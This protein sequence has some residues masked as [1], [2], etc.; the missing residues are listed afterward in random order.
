MRTIAKNILSLIALIL[1]GPQSFAKGPSLTPDLTLQQIVQTLE[2][3]A[4]ALIPADMRATGF[5]DF[6]VDQNKLS[7][8]LEKVPF[9]I[10]VIGHE[11]VAFIVN[12]QKFSQDDVRTRR[13]LKQAFLRKF[14][15]APQ[16]SLLIRLFVNSAFAAE[17][18]NAS[19][20]DS[21]FTG[22]VKE[23]KAVDSKVSVEQFP[24]VVY[25]QKSFKHPVYK[26]SDFKAMRPFM[27]FVTG[28]SMN[29]VFTSMQFL[30]SGLNHYMSNMGAAKPFLD[31]D[32][33]PTAVTKPT[34]SVF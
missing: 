30:F 26:P 34:F 29:N 9:L 10:E 3:S 6:K 16:Y 7:F 12:G 4:V 25:N 15:R 13:S 32:P 21:A 31:G 5:Y 19:F 27:N 24:P 20:D 2:P 17:P 33:D 11:D 18:F 8:T 23:V 14:R 28:P 22:E 1:V